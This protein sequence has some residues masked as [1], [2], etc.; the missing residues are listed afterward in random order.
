[1]S[2]SEHISKGCHLEKE[3]QILGKWAWS[4]AKVTENNKVEASGRS[5]SRR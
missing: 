5:L 1:M 2:E 4:E 3:C